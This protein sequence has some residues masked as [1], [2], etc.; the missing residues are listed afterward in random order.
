MPLTRVEREQVKDSRQKIESAA[1]TLKT[2][3]PKKIKG[4]PELED[5]LEEA[6][7]NLGEALRSPNLRGQ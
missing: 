3:D 2:V 5:C 7:Q 4:M 6:E 1:R